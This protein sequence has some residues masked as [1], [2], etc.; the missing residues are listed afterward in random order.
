V[1]YFVIWA[2]T[3]IAACQAQD[4]ARM[5]KMANGGKE[6]SV[7]DAVNKFLFIGFSVTTSGATQVDVVTAAQIGARGAHR[8]REIH[9]KTTLASGYL[10][11]GENASVISTQTNDVAPIFKDT[12]FDLED[13]NIS[14]LKLIRAA[15]DNVKVEGYVVI[16]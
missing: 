5:I 6:Q 15:S 11:L 14:Y 8:I 12:Y 7:R 4:H 2:G 10:G 1:Y 16:R 13:C 3:S 9:L